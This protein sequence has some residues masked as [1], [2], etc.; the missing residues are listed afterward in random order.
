MHGVQPGRHA[1]VHTDRYVQKQ[2]VLVQLQ[3]RA[4]TQQVRVQRQVRGHTQQQL[5]AGNRRRRHRY[6]C[7]LSFTQ[8]LI[9]QSE[10]FVETKEG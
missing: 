8:R 3:V 7:Y 9:R 5:A 6:A 10:E 1:A 4:Y 2:Q